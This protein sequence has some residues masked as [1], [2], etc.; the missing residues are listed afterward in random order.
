MIQKKGV[1]MFDFMNMNFTLFHGFSMFVFWAILVYL[2]FSGLNSKE[3]TSAI[4]IIKDRLAKG[5]I[6]KEEF[7]SLKTTLKTEI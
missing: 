1:I 7:E 5:E 6:S 4:D 2:I 3:K